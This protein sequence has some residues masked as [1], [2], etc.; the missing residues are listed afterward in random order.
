MTPSLSH[1]FQKQHSRVIV[2]RNVRLPAG[3]D[4]TP[5]GIRLVVASDV[6]AREDWFPRSC[7]ADLVRAMNAVEGA[8]AV[9]LIGDFVGDDPTAIDWAAEEFASIRVP[10]FATLGNHDYWTDPQRITDALVGAGGSVLTNRSTQLEDLHIA[11]IDSCWGGS[12]DA[13]AALEGVP[14]T[15][16]TVVLGHEPWL[17]TLHT[18]FLH[19]AGH[20]HAGQARLPIPKLGSRIAQLWMPRYSMPYPAG[21]YRRDERSWAYTTSGV[22]YST[23]SWRLATPPEIVV[24]DL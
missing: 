19:I 7:V 18:R 23:I 6:H 13:A 15:A 14:E 4:G 16:P 17:A 5:L 21:I 24:F 12:P 10:W 20:T 11:G 9:A 3:A 1:L 8:S 22:G 2:R